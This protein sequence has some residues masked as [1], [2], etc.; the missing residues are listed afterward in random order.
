MGVCKQAPFFYVERKEKMMRR[1]SQMKIKAC[2]I[3]VKSLEDDGTFTGYAS[4]FN[5]VDAHNDVVC[6]GAF[7][8]SLDRWRKKGAWPKMLW[9]HAH[10]QVVG[11][12]TQM[13]ED[14]VGLYVVGKLLL[15]VEKAREAYT[16]LKTKAVDNLSIGFRSKRSMRGRFGTRDVTYLHEVDLMEVSLVTFAANDEA[17]I[18]DVKSDDVV[19]DVIEGGDDVIVDNIID[20]R[21]VRKER[22]PVMKDPESIVWGIMRCPMSAIRAGMP[23]KTEE[24][25]RYLRGQ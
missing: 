11:V 24:L 10:D 13:F 5:Y 1:E 8:Q 9:Q 2:D 22:D 7:Q 19:I 4:I 6:R 23:T 21:V 18:L 20:N 16:L 15:D 17:R 14:E 25:C 12:W 3:V